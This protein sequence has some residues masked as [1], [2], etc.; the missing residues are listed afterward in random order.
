MDGRAELGAS[1]SAAWMVH[2]VMKD[3]GPPGRAE[4]RSTIGAGDHGGRRSR[5]HL[6]GPGGV[7]CQVVVP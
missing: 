3:S 5:G 6:R 4:M 2:Q 1:V 7:L